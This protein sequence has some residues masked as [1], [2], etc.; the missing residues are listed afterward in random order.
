MANRFTIKNPR[1]MQSTRTNMS[2]MKSE[3]PEKKEL[4]RGKFLFKYSSNSV[5]V[6]IDIITLY[7]RYVYY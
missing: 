4:V 3:K 6:I 5:F 7:S 2:T 1:A